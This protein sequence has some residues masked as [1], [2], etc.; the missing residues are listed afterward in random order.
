M[1]QASF[2]RY[3]IDHGRDRTEVWLESPLTRTAVN[4]SRDLE[5][6]LFA[7]C[8][9]FPT[10]SIQIFELPHAG[11]TDELHFVAIAVAHAGVFATLDDLIAEAV[12]ELG[13]DL[14]ATVLAA[15]AIG[16][17]VDLARVVAHHADVV[18]ARHLAAKPR[19]HLI[20]GA[21]EIMV[22]Q[23]AAVLVERLRG[24]TRGRAS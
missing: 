11:L 22:L 15:Q 14:E 9:V 5:P 7:R 4:G 23:R 19:R 10:T 12:L 20:V 2:Q 16:C 8:G 6:A 13:R 18:V 21:A 3:E 1:S 17:L 24:A